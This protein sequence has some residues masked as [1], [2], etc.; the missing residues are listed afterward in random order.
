MSDFPGFRLC[1]RFQLYTKE[2]LLNG[3]ASG[4]PD[5]KKAARFG[6]TCPNGGND[7]LGTQVWVQFSELG[8][9]LAIFWPG[10][11]RA[12]RVS[13][14]GAPV[15]RVFVA[16]T[17]SGH[18]TTVLDFYRMVKNVYNSESTYLAD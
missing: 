6:S 10:P 15:F 9:V 2:L 7:D 3:V 1:G 16:A 11:I 12:D 5:I 14:G 13:R 17:V 4:R 8:Q 18:R